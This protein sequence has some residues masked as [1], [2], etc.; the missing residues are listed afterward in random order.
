[1]RAGST[2]GAGWG[3]RWMGWVMV[4]VTGQR[5]IARQKERLDGVRGGRSNAREVAVNWWA[6]DLLEGGWGWGDCG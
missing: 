3:S 4:G 6:A 2:M 1:M 5:V